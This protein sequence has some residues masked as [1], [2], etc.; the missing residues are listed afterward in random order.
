MKKILLA[1]V[2]LGSVMTAN[3]QKGTWLL[4]GN[5]GLNSASDAQKNKNFNWNVNPGVGYQ[6]SDHWTAGINLG[7][8]Q[9]SY[10]ANGTSDKTTVNSYDLGLFGRYTKDI[11][12]MFYLYGQLDLGY[13]G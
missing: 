6:F 1:V 12:D 2:A 8:G 3:A 5:V 10:K 4:Y 7:W 13:Q 9:Y 11:N